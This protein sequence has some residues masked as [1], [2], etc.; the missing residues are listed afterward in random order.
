MFSEECR[1]NDLDIEDQDHNKWNLQVD[2]EAR[3]DGIDPRKL[4]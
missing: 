2:R 3:E 1:E 4:E